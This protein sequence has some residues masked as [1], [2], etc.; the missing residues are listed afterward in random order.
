MYGSLEYALT[1]WGGLE[2]LA[3]DAL[4]DRRI[5]VV[6]ALL[7]GRGEEE[8]LLEH[9]AFGVALALLYGR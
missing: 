9:L 3:G 6:S 7:R 4:P 5:P 1:P 2:G 8:A